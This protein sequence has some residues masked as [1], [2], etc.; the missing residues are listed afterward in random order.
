M[1]YT[2]ID[3]EIILCMSAVI[4]LRFS[5]SGS[6]CLRWGLISYLLF[7]MQIQSML[8]KC[9]YII[10]LYTNTRIIASSTLPSPVLTNFPH[11]VF[12]WCFLIVT[13]TH[14]SDGH[15]CFRFGCGLFTDL[16]PRHL[17][18]NRVVTNMY[19]TLLS[20]YTHCSQGTGGNDHFDHRLNT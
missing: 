11:I 1:A 19:A 8:N 9:P 13:L 20:G 6:N 14:I 10:L 5:T 12:P 4:Y 3:I 16:F 2:K 17:S 18:G 7:G 15:S